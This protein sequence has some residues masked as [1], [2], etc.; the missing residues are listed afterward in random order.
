MDALQFSVTPYSFNAL[1]LFII[2]LAGMLYLL[3]LKTKTSAIHAMKLVMAG[4]T[5][6]MAS[7]LANNIVFWGSALTPFT[8]ACVVVSIAVVILLA[9][10]YPQPVKSL[11]ARL[12]SSF[13]ALVAL[14]ALFFSLYYALQFFFTRGAAMS[15]LP[16]FFWIL[17]PLISVLAVLV[18]LRRTFMLQSSLRTGG[19]RDTLSALWRPAI[20]PVRLLRNFSLTVAVGMVQGLVSALDVVIQF[21]PMLASLLINLS[22]GLMFVVLVYSI[23]DLTD[24]QPRLIV[25]LVGLSLVTVLGIA[26]IVGT[27]TFDLASESVYAQVH[28]DVALTRS[29]LSAGSS[30]DWPENVAYILAGSA[31]ETAAKANLRLVYA[32]PGLQT[33][34]LLEESLSQAV[35]PVWGYFI[36][37]KAI[38]PGVSFAQLSLRYGS[39]P[40]GSYYQYVG[41]PVTQGGQNYEIGFSM[42]K[43]DQA[44]QAKSRW[45]WALILFSS[46]L[47]LG[48]F[49]RFF[50]A[51][52]IRPLERLSDGVRQADDGDLEVSVPVTYQ[53]EVGFLTTAFNKLIAS[54]KDE[55][56][57]RQR[58][59]AELRQLNLTLEQRVADRTRE[60]EALYDVSA[61]A[62][63]AHDSSSLL[64]SMLERSLAALNSSAGFIMLLEDDTLHLAAGRGLPA[65][66]S[67]ALASA[68]A[69][70]TLFETALKESVPLLIPDLSREARAPDFLRSGKPLTLLLAPLI[71]DG[72]PL[73]LM[74]LAR[75]AR[76]DFDLDEVALLVSIISQVASAVQTDRLRQLAQHAT[77]FEERQRLARDLHDSVTQSLYG[78]AT[79]TEAGKMRLEA[80]DLTAS[81]HYLTRIGQTARQAIREMRLF[82]HQLRPLVLEKE[83]LVGAL[84]LRLAAVEGRSDVRATLEADEQLTLPPQVE[85][86]LYHIAQEALNNALKHSAASVVSVRLT[87]AGQGALL[88]I[89]DNGCG[90]DPEQVESGG[91][92]LENMRV[93]AAAIGAVLEIQSKKEHGTRIRV[94][95]ERLP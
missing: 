52:L 16:A 36:N 23:F 82:L 69:E 71:A 38:C 61:A 68:S 65:G 22:L 33:Q 75:A 66:W 11:E 78:L 51:S 44:F 1:A 94:Q 76:R 49:P 54:L 64:N 59:E 95:L 87:R 55:L 7:W 13:A 31:E 40:P 3:G 57:Q 18:C 21:P 37:L 85:T 67:E 8:E 45:V 80:G 60:L 35:P 14:A 72:K 42:A 90:F 56:A 24:E 20:R 70:Q 91:M 81:A 47:V 28:S 58:V 83:G 77:V 46:L 6:G 4:F 32:Q 39:H 62:S 12:L 92:G 15:P 79:L 30:A 84:E 93:R 9:Y 25:R 89:E 29:A 10:R 17:N 26:G 53:D 48:V 5:L 74:G 27:Y 73:G 19:W 41:C 88:E 43:M 86:A 34:P 63:Q 2:G 50:R